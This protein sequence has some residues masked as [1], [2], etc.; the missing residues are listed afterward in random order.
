MFLSGP[1]VRRSVKKTRTF[2]LVFLMYI[3]FEVCI[4]I[5]LV[6][7]TEIADIKYTPPTL[8]YF[9]CSHCVNIF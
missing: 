5:M 3:D 9:I 4:I 1:E 2:S 7:L 8:D 6:F